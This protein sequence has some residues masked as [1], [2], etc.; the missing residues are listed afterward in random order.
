MGYIISPI[1]A[2][3]LIHAVK[4]ELKVFFSFL[5]NWAAHVVPVTIVESSFFISA[6]FIVPVAVIVLDFKVV[7]PCAVLAGTL[8]AL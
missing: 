3:L 5:P 4:P 2:D 1:F 7:V 8:T 6:V